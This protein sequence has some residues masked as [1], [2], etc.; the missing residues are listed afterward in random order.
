MNK[1]STSVASLL[2]LMSMSFSSFVMA[3]ESAMEAAESKC[4]AKAEEQ[5]IS[6]EKFDDFV[7]KCIEDMMSGK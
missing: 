1:I 3:Q 6:D 2:L 7:E 5:N 4:V